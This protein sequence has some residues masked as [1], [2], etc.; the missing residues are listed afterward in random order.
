[1]S[2]QICNTA[3]DDTLAITRE[4]PMI[5]KF[6]F[7]DIILITELVCVVITF[8]LSFYQILRHALAYTRP[9]EQKY[10][11]RIL[12]MV[13]LYSFANL[14]STEFLPYATYFLILSSS[15]AA[16]AVASYFS[17][18]CHYLAPDGNSTSLFSNITPR[19]WQNCFPLPLRWMRDH[20][21]GQ[22]Y[23]LAT[24]NCGLKWFKSLTLNALSAT[25]AM[26]CLDQFTWQMKQKLSVHK[27]TLKLCLFWHSSLLLGSLQRPQSDLRV[28]IPSLMLCCELLFT[29]MLHMHAFSWKEYD[30]QSVKG[31][32]QGGLLGGRAVLE[33][34][35][36]ID[37]VRACGAA[38]EW[39]LKK[40]KTDWAP[41]RNEDDMSLST[42]PLSEEKY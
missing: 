24:P 37:I 19:P 10:I 13:P 21:G 26:Y 29:S 27:P 18:L 2:N 30:E 39:L 36:M 31:K 41:E 17:L 28:G 11:L 35:N 23:F 42:A 15:Y 12:F 22:T 16:I 14:L 7:H 20:L 6:T 25:I 34:L 1:M 3:D 5:G 4:L 32:H 8:V 40:K 9:T 38:M 33:A